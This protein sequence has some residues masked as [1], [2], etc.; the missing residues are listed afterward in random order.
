[1]LVHAFLDLF[2]YIL[3]QLM[4]F[5]RFGTLNPT[6]SARIDGRWLTLCFA[7]ATPSYGRRK[8]GSVNSAAEPNGM[9]SSRSLATLWCLVSWSIQQ[10]F[11]CFLLPNALHS[12]EGIA[13]NVSIWAFRRARWAN[14]V[15]ASL[16]VHV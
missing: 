9:G 6:A 16:D 7:N 12:I 1:M 15:L 8:V 11:L 5:P 4:Q 3:D 2:D 13:T 14:D 10:P